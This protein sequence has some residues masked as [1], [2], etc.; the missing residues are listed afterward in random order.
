M[1]K[2]SLTTLAGAFV[3]AGIV[4]GYGLL[5]AT[6][7]PQEFRPFEG[8]FGGQNTTAPGPGLP[9]PGPGG[10]ADFTFTGAGTFQAT[11]LGHGEFTASGTLEYDR[12]QETPAELPN[13]VECGFVDG[14]ITL[15]AANGDTLNGQI[16]GNRSVICNGGNANPLTALSTLFVEVAG[17]TGRFADATG[18]YFIKSTSVPTTN[19]D[20]GTGVGTYDETGYM[21]GSIDY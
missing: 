16:E 10:G 19:V 17:G 2:T 1:R 3:A 11:H 14:T 13:D 20:Q 12:H 18:Y 6:A 9:I 5:G 21:F 4:G 7:A 8:T 15:T